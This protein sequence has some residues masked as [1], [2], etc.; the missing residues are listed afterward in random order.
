MITSLELKEVRWLGDSRK[1]AHRFPKGARN[2]LGKELTRVQMGLQP[3]DGKWLNDVGPGVQEIR[4]SHNKE[5]YRAIY[6]AKLADSIYVL[7]AFHK[8]AKKGIAT[9]QEDIDLAT[10]RY[11]DL[12]RSLRRS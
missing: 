10:K 2:A 9:P 6:V 12:V 7:H 1:I 5:A 3:R 4:I 8:K 11:K